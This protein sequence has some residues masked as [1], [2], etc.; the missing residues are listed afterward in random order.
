MAQRITRSATR[1]Q[2]TCSGHLQ[3]GHLIFFRVR[4]E[5]VIRQEPLECGGSAAAA[6]DPIRYR[7]Q[8]AATFE[9]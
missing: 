9:V 2:A 3:V 1:S 5:N 8:L 4:K 7:S 6:F